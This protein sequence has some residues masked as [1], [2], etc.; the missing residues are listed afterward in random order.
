MPKGLLVGLFGVERIGEAESWLRAAVA[1]AV[2]GVAGAG[3]GGPCGPGLLSR[4]SL[5][6]W[7]WRWV[8]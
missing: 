8:V 4:F 5:P 2:V 7:S 3:P 1:T 6:P